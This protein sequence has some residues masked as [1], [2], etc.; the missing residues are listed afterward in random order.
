MNTRPNCI[1]DILY[2]KFNWIDTIDTSRQTQIK[3]YN[4]FM[5]CTHYMLYIHMSMNINKCHAGAL[6]KYLCHKWPRICYVC[7]NCNP[8]LSPF[9]TITTG[10]L[11]KVTRLVSL[12][13]QE[14]LFFRITWVHHRFFGHLFILNIFYS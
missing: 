5:Q 14:L 3:E 12:V 7:R 8:V 4:S 2:F 13:K 10:F 6:G 9:M 11:T 1:C